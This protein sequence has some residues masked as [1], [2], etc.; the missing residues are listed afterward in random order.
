MVN[1]DMDTETTRRHVR[2]MHT[3]HIHGQNDG[4]TD[5]RL[6][7]RRMGKWMDRQNADRQED[8][9]TTVKLVIAA[10]CVDQPPSY[11]FMFAWSQT[12]PPH[13]KTSTDQPQVLMRC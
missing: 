1:E 3:V 4:W 11:T 2:L 6:I 7:D 13:D 8:T 5:E 12:V 9:E 10:P